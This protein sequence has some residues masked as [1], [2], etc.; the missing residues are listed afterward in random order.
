MTR[1]A[2]KTPGVMPL[3]AF[4]NFGVNAKVIDNPMGRFGTGLKY[5]LAVI[6]RMGGSF[7]VW[8]EGV[9]HVFY[10]KKQD[11][12]GKEFTFVRMKKAR[13]LLSKAGWSYTKLPFTTDLGKDW[14][15]WQAFRELKSNTDDENGEMFEVPEDYVVSDYG[16]TIIIR[17]D[18]LAEILQGSEPVFLSDLITSA[19]PVWS[20]DFVDIYPMSSNVLYFRGVRVYDLKHES[21]FTYNFKK[22]IELTEDRTIKNIWMVE[23]WLAERIRNDIKDEGLL[24][25]MLKK[26]TLA[27][28][29]EDLQLHG[30]DTN[31]LGSVFRS[32]VL[33]LHHAGNAS[34]SASLFHSTYM[35]RPPPLSQ[36][37]ITLPKE[38]WQRIEK[39]LRDAGEDALADMVEVQ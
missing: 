32:T 4:S 28:E 10:L 1:I 15:L 7:D 34:R 13:G 20:D 18:G 17:V 2:F 33:S 16:T 21:R 6:L 8:I 30:Y 22:N 37:T 3:E 26:D 39:A 9:H 38:D 12:R 25:K 24:R 35:D 23:F 5:A 14:K 11:F 27:Y 19:L 36:R 31:E 29:T